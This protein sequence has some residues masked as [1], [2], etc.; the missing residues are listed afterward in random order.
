M[1]VFKFVDAILIYTKRVLYYIVYNILYSTVL[2]D[3]I[4]HL[5]SIKLVVFRNS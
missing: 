3:F 5:F 1:Q 4:T 2:L